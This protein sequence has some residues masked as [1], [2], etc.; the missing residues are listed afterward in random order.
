MAAP[1]LLSQGPLQTPPSS[2][3]AGGLRLCGT[4]RLQLPACRWAWGRYVDSISQ[5]ASGLGQDVPAPIRAR[6]LQPEPIVSRSR[7]GSGL[8]LRGVS[9][10]PSRP[11][12]AACRLAGPPTFP[13]TL[14][15]W[16]FPGR[17]HG[18]WYSVSPSSFPTGLGRRRQRGRQRPS[19][20]EAAAAGPVMGL[21]G[22]G[23]RVPPHPFS[24]SAFGRL[25]RSGQAQSRADGGVR[26]EGSSDGSGRGAGS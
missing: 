8:L 14:M 11:L 12:L 4:R 13:P 6:A 5:H 17:R 23:R 18:P 19:R 15:P 21:G 16:E 24:G 25:W 7:G 1:N 10:L 3:L 20:E 26:S 2:L 22:A 9:E